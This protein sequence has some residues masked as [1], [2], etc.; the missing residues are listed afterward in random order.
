MAQRPDTKTDDLKEL[1]RRLET[2]SRPSP[3]IMNLLK[4]MQNGEELPKLVL[5]A[6]PGSYKERMEKEKRRERDR[7]DRERD[8]DRD[9]DRDRGREVGRYRS[10]S[11]SRRRSRR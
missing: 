10:R 4:K 8:R 6:Q 3:L 9:R 2:C 1:D 7:L 11:R 5:E